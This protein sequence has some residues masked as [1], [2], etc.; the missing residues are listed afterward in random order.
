LE[1][2]QIDVLHVA[3]HPVRRQILSSLAGSRE[4][5]AKLASILNVNVKLIQFHLAVLEKHGLV[6]AEFAL[7]ESANVPHPVAVR[8]FGL[9]LAGVGVAGTICRISGFDDL[10]IS[11]RR[12]GFASTVSSFAQKKG[13]RRNK[14][15]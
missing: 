12:E 3:L 10:T 8:S 13:T 11:A 9:T 6:E 4:Y 1:P 2:A 5:A 14:I 15:R 7:A